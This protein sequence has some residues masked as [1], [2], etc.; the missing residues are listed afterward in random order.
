MREVELQAFYS[1][2]LIPSS[3]YV[4]LNCYNLSYKAFSNDSNFCL[5]IVQIVFHFVFWFWLLKILT[6]TN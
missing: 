4:L 6:D 2:I 5:Y 3:T 1:A